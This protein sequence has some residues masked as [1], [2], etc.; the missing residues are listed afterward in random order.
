VDERTVAEQSI[1]WSG[2]IGRLAAFVWRSLTRRYLAIEAA[3]L[4]QRTEQAASTTI[5]ATLPKVGYHPT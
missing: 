4:K 5:T 2:P 1:A 3:G